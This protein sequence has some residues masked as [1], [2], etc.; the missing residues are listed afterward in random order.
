MRSAIAR[1]PTSH[2]F[3]GQ[4]AFPSKDL[5]YSANIFPSLK[6]QANRTH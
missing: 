3:T 5:T 2:S 6:Q 1:E 4:F